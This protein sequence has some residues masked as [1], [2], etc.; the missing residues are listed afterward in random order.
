MP[1]PAQT[2]DSPPLESPAGW[3]LA[4]LRDAL[5]LLQRGAEGVIDITEGLHQSVRG[6]L[7]LAHGPSPE[8]CGGLSGQVYGWVRGAHGL[9]G[10]G[11]QG[12]L[13]IL[14][15]RREQALANLSESGRETRPAPLDPR[16]LAWLSVLNG[17]CGD[18]LQASGS[19]LAIAPQLLPA[20]ARRG[21]A[22]PRGRSARA[23]SRHV[24]V[25][26][27]G[28]C[29][30]D[31]Q[32]RSGDDPGH[33]EALAEALGATPKYFR[34][35][36]GLSIAHNGRALSEALDAWLAEQDRAPARISL[37]GHSM[38]G[39][40]ARRAELEAR[41]SGRT[42]REALRELV[43]IGT[44]NEGAPLERL[45]HAF[46]RV[47][48]AAP[49]AHHFTRLGAV[50]SRGI[51]DLRHAELG[52]GS[53]ADLPEDVRCLRIAGLLAGSAKGAGAGW[54]GDGLVP[55][56][57]ALGRQRFASARARG[58]ELT[59]PSCGHLQ[60]LRS[61]AVRAPMRDWL[62]GG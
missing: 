49:Y 41:A 33:G 2:S 8:R 20:Q 24:L 9:L 21:H 52:E 37:I 54:I 53:A 18:H 38:G 28:L 14:E 3:S 42:W 17:V 36:S 57:S 7:G 5:A 45:G 35:N 29:M 59:V 43:L 1:A 48:A 34:Y 11:L 4:E 19:A 15:R 39:L 47:L 12:A 55:V 22:K 32:W 44:P 60:L 30:N 10:S 58:D 50:R 40:V 13:K 62:Q 6:T 23:R 25:L 51:L 31:L 16:R 46:E 56:D 61:E 27:H 26:I